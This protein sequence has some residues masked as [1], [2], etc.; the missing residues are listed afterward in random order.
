MKSR[1]GAA[2][3]SR[4]RNGPIHQKRLFRNCSTNIGSHGAHTAAPAPIASVDRRLI[5]RACG[6]SHTQASTAA[7]VNTKK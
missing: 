1:N 3:A 2:A 7:T 4:T 5:A 6:S